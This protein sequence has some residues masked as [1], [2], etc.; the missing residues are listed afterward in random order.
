MFH[1]LPVVSWASD[2]FGLRRMNQIWETGSKLQDPAAPPAPGIKN[3]WLQ[4]RLQNHL[5]HWKRKNIILFVQLL[6]PA[7][8]GCGSG[9]QISGSGSAPP[10]ESFGLRILLF[11]ASKI[12]CAPSP[13]PWHELQLLTCFVFHQDCP[14]LSSWTVYTQCSV[15]CGGGTRRR[16]RVCQPAGANC[17]GLGPLEETTTCNGHVSWFIAI[18]CGL[19]RF[20][21]QSLRDGLQKYKLFFQSELCILVP[22]R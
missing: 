16:T 14:N 12:A 11:Q 17:S 18:G 9:T 10:S 22:H 4:L 8:W 1:A 15:S 20:A 6:C 19:L 7:N 13:Q 2:H 21:W 5:V 3:F